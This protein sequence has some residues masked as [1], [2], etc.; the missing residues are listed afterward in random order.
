MAETE[1]PLLGER[2]VG[3]EGFRIETQDTFHLDQKRRE[4]SRHLDNL[5][6]VEHFC[7]E[8]Q[9]SQLY[10][11]ALSAMQAGNRKNKDWMA[12]SAHSLRE[13]FYGVNSIRKPT[14]LSKKMLNYVPKPVVYWLYKN[15]R[16][17]NLAKI[18][19]NYQK[20]DVAEK[21]AK[22][23]NDLYFVFTQIAHHFNDRGRHRDVRNVLKKFGKDFEINAAKDFNEK[24]YEKLVLLFENIW[25]GYRPYQL[26]IHKELDSILKDV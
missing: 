3:I 17:G 18:I 16:R 20:R 19:E 11:G 24:H 25:I 23:L 7:A 22:S 6:A 2:A 21:M 10:E 12:Q 15:N 8:V 13:L 26:E 1:D 4:I 5:N 9:P 14:V